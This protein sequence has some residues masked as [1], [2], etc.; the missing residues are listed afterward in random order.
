[1]TCRGKVKGHHP[2]ARATKLPKKT[3]EDGISTE[4]TCEPGT[5]LMFELY[6][7]G[8]GGTLIQPT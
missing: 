8:T 3:R 1:M 7:S 4:G 6:G 5:W 2:I